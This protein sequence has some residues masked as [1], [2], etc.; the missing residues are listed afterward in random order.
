MFVRSPEEEEEEEEEEDRDAAG[1]GGDAKHQSSAGGRGHK[2]RLWALEQATG[3]WPRLPR[4][5]PATLLKFLVAHAYYEAD[6]EETAERREEARR[7][8]RR[9]L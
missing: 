5:A 9:S 1:E 6:P 7:A 8:P 4:D 2:R 3:L